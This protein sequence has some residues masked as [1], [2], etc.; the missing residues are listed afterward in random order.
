V[1]AVYRAD[2]RWVFATLNRLLGNSD[3]AEEALHDAFVSAVEQWPRDGVP[4]NP[5][6]WLVSAGRFKAIDGLRRAARLDAS[7]ANLAT[8][9][10]ATSCDAP[11]MDDAPIEDERLRLIFAC[12][13]PVLSQDAQVALALREVCGLT[14]EQIASAFRTSPSTLAQRIVRAKAKI[15]CA[16]NVLTVPTGADLADRLNA[17]LQVIYLMFH[18]A[19]AGTSVPPSAR[20]DHCEE[21]IRLGRLL[22]KLLP[23]P[24]VTGLLSLMLLQDARR[25][26]PTTPAGG[27]VPAV[28]K[29]PSFWNQ[30][31]IAEGISLLDRARS[32]RRIGPYT[33]QAAILSAQCCRRA[34][35]AVLADSKSD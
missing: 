11:A 23:E 12:C 25:T 8:R 24:E 1:D 6:A 4:A 3:L 16:R 18:E 22:V 27:E 7:L 35:L 26:L 20:P 10:D 31:R 5:Q 15:R 29:D 14:T 33:R 21:A 19:Y 34:I 17:V 2:S 13:H 30:E 28:A 32:S 9:L